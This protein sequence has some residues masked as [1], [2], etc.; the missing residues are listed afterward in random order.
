MET[1]LFV[2]FFQPGEAFE[3]ELPPVGPL[4]HVVARPRQLVAERSAVHQAPEANVAIERWLEAE[5]ELQRALGEEPGGTKRSEMRVTARDGV[6]VRFAVFGDARERDLVPELGP[7]AVVVVGRRSVEA[8][9]Q[10]LATRGASDLA[11]WDL[12][13]MAGRDLAGIH[14]PDVAFRAQGGAFHPAI[15]PIA[16]RVAVGA[17]PPPPRIVITPEPAPVA[18]PPP[19]P[20]PAAVVPS[21]P[22]PPPIAAPQ[23]P[24]PVAPTV[25]ASAPTEEPPAL[26][27]ADLALIERMDREREEEQLR[28]RMQEEERRR[29]GVGEAEDPATTWAM[30]Y[31][32]QAASAEAASRAAAAESGGGLELG[33]LLWRLRFAMLGLLVIAIGAYG[34]LSLRSGAAVSLGGGGQ[35]FE[36]V[37]IAQKVSSARWDYVVNG[38]QRVQTAGTSRADGTFYVV[39]IGVTNR[40]TE[41]AQLSPAE[42]T[43]ID[44]NGTE[45]RAESVSSDAYYGPNNTSSQYVWPQSFAVGKT[46]S[47]VVIFDVSTSLGRGNKLAVDDL[48]RTRFA[49]D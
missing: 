35:S 18:A 39:R 33:A 22:L 6:F 23:P 20:V 47:I 41:G 17:E 25:V 24:P 27:P 48:P 9:G 4:V 36:S 34:F 38:V 12:T 1:G 13:S 26:T 21:E 40:G 45:Y 8:D 44:A 42:F 10:V 16:A 11:P 5:L 49:L 2:M 19:A 30:R 43:L 37:G 31:R 14:K 29:L 28:A 46:A 3:R 32:E 7:F 15:A